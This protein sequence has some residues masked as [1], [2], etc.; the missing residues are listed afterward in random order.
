MCEFVQQ[1][2]EKYRKITVRDESSSLKKKISELMLVRLNV[3]VG[4]AAERWG[5]DVRNMFSTMSVFFLLSSPSY[6][7]HSVSS[8]PQE[9]QRLKQELLKSQTMVSCLQSEMDSLKTE[10]TDQSI[11]SERYSFIFIMCCSISWSLVSRCILHLSQWESNLYLF[12]VKPVKVV[13]LVFSMSCNSFV[14]YFEI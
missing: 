13:E 3:F 4:V 1:I 5:C 6:S 9:N 7:A 2:E 12:S 8:S 14:F 11:N 10:L